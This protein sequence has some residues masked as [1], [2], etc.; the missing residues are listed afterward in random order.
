MVELYGHVPTASLRESARLGSHF[1]TLAPIVDCV[2]SLQSSMQ[3]A[4]FTLSRFV[5]SSVGCCP[6]MESGQHSA[7]R[8]RMILL[9][10]SDGGASICQSVRVEEIAR[11]TEHQSAVFTRYLLTNALATSLVSRRMSWC[12]AAVGGG[13]SAVL[14]VCESHTSACTHSDSL[15]GNPWWRWMWAATPALKCAYDS[16]RA[17]CLKHAFPCPPPS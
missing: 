1:A 6:H 17:H 14:I 7:I 12:G 3:S 4:I 5:A 11:L 13:C 10:A 15:A 2:L 9:D 8:P 16:N